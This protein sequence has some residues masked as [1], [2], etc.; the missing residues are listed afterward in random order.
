[1]SNFNVNNFPM[2]P[3]VYFNCN[4]SIPRHNAFPL[5]GSIADFTTMLLNDS[6]DKYII[7]PGYKLELFV[8]VDYSGGSNGSFDNTYGT[9]LVLFAP[10]TE[11]VS[12]SCKIYFNNIIIPITIYRN[13]P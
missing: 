10:T 9:T 2:V 13:L 12:S 11:D 3:G 6:D 8:G 4:L 7:L 1:M 5:F